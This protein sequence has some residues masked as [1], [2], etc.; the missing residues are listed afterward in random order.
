MITSL[1]IDSQ[2]EHELLDLDAD[3]DSDTGVRQYKGYHLLR[4]K[5]LEDKHIDILKFLDKGI[6]QFPIKFEFLLIEKY[7]SGF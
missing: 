1:K 4:V 2:Q 5:L 3:I 7:S 6:I